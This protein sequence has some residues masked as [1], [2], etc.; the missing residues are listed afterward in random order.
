[1]AISL[2][3]GELFDKITLQGDE[4]ARFFHEATEAIRMRD[5]F[6]AMA[7]HELNTPTASRE[8]LLQGI[9]KW[10]I[11]ASGAPERVCDVAE[12]GDAPLNVSCMQAGRLATPSSRSTAS[13]ADTAGEMREPST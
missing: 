10:N 3:N 2:E 4:K 7:S 5:D 11:P 6:M 13:R 9:Q 1:M 8:L 12:R